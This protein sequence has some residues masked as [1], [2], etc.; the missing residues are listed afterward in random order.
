MSLKSII[1]PMDPPSLNIEVSEL[2]ILDPETNKYTSSFAY[3][4]NCSIISPSIS[5]ISYLDIYNSEIPS[6]SLILAFY[7]TNIPTEI[8]CFKCARLVTLPSLVLMTA[9]LI[10]SCSNKPHKS[11]PS[12]VISR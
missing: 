8:T 6:V 5:L 2:F 7:Y 1:L 9:G 4:V 10:L 11:F 12:K 3:S